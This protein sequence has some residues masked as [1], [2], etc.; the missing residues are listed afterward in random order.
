MKQVP[1]TP[2]CL[3]E[4]PAQ[5]PMSNARLAPRR[6]ATVL[7]S[8]TPFLAVYLIFLTFLIPFLCCLYVWLCAAGGY[9]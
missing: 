5:L 9:N 2:R 4:Q 8:L 3:A 6:H 1:E 7:L